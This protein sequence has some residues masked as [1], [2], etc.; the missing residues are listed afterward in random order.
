[1][2]QKWDPPH[3]HILSLQDST[4]V[5]PSPRSHLKEPL[6]ERHPFT[7]KQHY[8]AISLAQLMLK[9]HILY[10]DDVFGRMFLFLLVRLIL[11]IVDFLVHFPIH[12]QN[13]ELLIRRSTRY[14]RL[15]K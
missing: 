15:R 13:M 2:N 11:G 4:S 10:V 3:H 5:P 7:T 14:I 1:M 12:I 6:L 8:M 9:Y